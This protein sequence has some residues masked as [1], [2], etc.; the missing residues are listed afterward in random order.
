MSLYKEA[1]NNLKNYIEQDL[2]Y[3][4]D[5]PQSDFDEFCINHCED[6]ET[7]LNYIKELEYN[8]EILKKI[9]NAKD[10]LIDTLEKRLFDTIDKETLRKINANTD[11]YRDFTEEVLKLL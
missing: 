11:T 9:P 3:K 1:I 4:E 10:K 7:V 2:I 6:I 8:N 5:K